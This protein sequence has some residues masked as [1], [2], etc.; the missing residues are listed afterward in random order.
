MTFPKSTFPVAEKLRTGHIL[1][2]VNLYICIRTLC[3]DTFGN[4]YREENV[5]SFYVSPLQMS[6]MELKG[7]VADDE[8]HHKS[9]GI[10]PMEHSLC[11]EDSLTHWGTKISRYCTVLY[12]CR[13]HPEIFIRGQN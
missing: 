6:Q 4:L 10:P 13:V 3:M 12:I 1:N 7:G 11:L 2:I 9:T 5:N 8:S